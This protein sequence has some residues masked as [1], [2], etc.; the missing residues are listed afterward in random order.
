M[1]HQEAKDLLMPY[2]MDDLNPQER[3]AFERALEQSVALQEELTLA[4]EDLLNA[5]NKGAHSPPLSVKKAISKEIRVNKIKELNATNPTVTRTPWYY[6]LAAAVALIS[7][8][9]NFL[10][11][12]QYLS[13]VDYAISLENK[14]SF[15]ADLQNQNQQTVAELSTINQ[16]LSS[17]EARR[18]VLKGLD[19]SPD[20]EALVIWDTVSKSTFLADVQLPE[21][22]SGLQYQLWALKDGKPISAGVFDW[23]G[24]FSLTEMNI[25]AQADAFAVSLEK[26]GGSESPQGDIY[27]LGEVKSS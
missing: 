12:Q 19:P 10:L 26:A 21:P 1:E 24:S 14:V 17:A 7:L 25:T 16:I 6:K 20:A 18:I 2:L 13:S 5:L 23:S 8:A 4:E 11:Y 3:I 27:L 9:I 22:P 15:M